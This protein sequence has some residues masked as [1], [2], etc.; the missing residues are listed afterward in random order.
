MRPL[1]AATNDSGRRDAATAWEERRNA[2]R[3]TDET[4]RMREEWSGY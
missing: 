2:R 4:F 3:A 1:Q